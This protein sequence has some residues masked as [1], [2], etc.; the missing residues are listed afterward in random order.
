MAGELIGKAGESGSQKN[1]LRPLKGS[2]KSSPFASQRTLVLDNLPGIASK[3]KLG[4]RRQRENGREQVN[5]GVKW[6]IKLEDYRGRLSED[7]TTAY[8]QVIPPTDTVLEQKN[9][10][11]Q[12][13]EII[14]VPVATTPRTFYTP[15]AEAFESRHLANTELIQA[16]FLKLG[17]DEQLARSFAVI[18]LGK[19][20]VAPINPNAHAFYNSDG[21]LAPGKEGFVYYRMAFLLV[22]RDDEQAV[23]SSFW[24]EAGHGYH[25]KI[26]GV[27]S[28][29]SWYINPKVVKRT[30]HTGL[31]TEIIGGL[32]GAGGVVSATA[33][34]L[35]DSNPALGF[36][37][38][39][40]GGLLFAAGATMRITPSWVLKHLDSHERYANRFYSQDSH[41][42]VIHIED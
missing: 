35:V 40:A 25:D 41:P 14:E 4:R 29:E 19:S 42:N 15:S 6:D 23:N 21:F 30:Q 38:L 11:R 32:V 24:H 39:A 18:F 2:M 22:C 1:S 28:R 7:G 12:D 33:S 9:I 8:F 27:K 13:P 20:D 17:F 26:K 5:P 3:A 16:E 37:G 34:A 31:A 36:G 10:T